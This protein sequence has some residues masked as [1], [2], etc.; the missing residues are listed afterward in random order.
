MLALD[1]DGAVLDRPAAAAFL[2]EFFGEGFQVIFGENEI[3]DEGH[4]LPAASALVTVQVG[5][6]TLRRERV[7]GKDDGGFLSQVVTTQ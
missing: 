1:F 6:L 2:F 7:A 5:G 3:L 4:H